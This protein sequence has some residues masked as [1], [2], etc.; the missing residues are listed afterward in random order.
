MYYGIEK[1]RY[2][3]RNPTLLLALLLLVAYS[4]AEIIIR[5]DALNKISCGIGGY[6]FWGGILLLVYCW[7]LLPVLR[8]VSFP[9]WTDPEKLSYGRERIAYL[10]KMGKY[11]LRLFKK[12]AP[13]EIKEL[14]AELKKTLCNNYLFPKD[15]LNKLSEIVPEIHHRLLENVSERIIRDYMKKTG[16]LVC[17]SQRGWL[18]SAAMLVMQIRM[19]IDLSRSLGYRPSWVFILYSLVW[20]MIN[21]ILFAFFDGSDIVEEAETELL[22]LALGESASGALPLIGKFLGIAA[23][24]VSAM[25][26]MYVTGQVIKRKLT[27]NPVRL[28]GKDRV[29]FRI[30][31]YKAAF[32]VLKAKSGTQTA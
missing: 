7:I 32:D 20:V 15:Y 11:Y 13:V 16:I 14:I 17:I 28:D 1:M 19:I 21:S 2:L 23:Q 6:F 12:D 24:G 22:P 5:G 26:V 4:G 25:A 29:K 30:D 18:D 8:F 9:T 31:G 27:G 10:E 3:F